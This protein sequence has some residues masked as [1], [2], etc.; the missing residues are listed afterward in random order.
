[1]PVI[2][3]FYGEYGLG[4]HDVFILKSIYSVAAV[5]PFI[6]WLNDMYSLQTALL[7]SAGN[8]FLP[9]IFFLILQIKNSPKQG[10]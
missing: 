6:G 3:W 4:L 7:V 10:Y 2:G 9:G 1:M 5:A 8:I